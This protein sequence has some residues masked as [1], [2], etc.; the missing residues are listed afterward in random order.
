MHNDTCRTVLWIEIGLMNVSK[1]SRDTSPLSPYV[2]LGLLSAM[3]NHKLKGNIP[4]RYGA[5]VDRPGV[6]DLSSHTLYQKSVSLN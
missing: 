4:S 1:Y 2:P 5:V 6:E 3:E